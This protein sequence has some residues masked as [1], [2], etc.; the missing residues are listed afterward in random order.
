MRGGP[1][2]IDLLRHPGDLQMGDIIGFDHFPGHL[3]RRAAANAG[4]HLDDFKAG[5]KPKYRAIVLGTTLASN[6]GDKVDGILIFP[7]APIA[8]DIFIE[9]TNTRFVITK[10][11]DKRPT[12]LD[13]AK[14]WQV[15]YVPIHLPV[16]KTTMGTDEDLKVQKYGTLPHH[17]IT[18]I[19]DHT[20]S[21][22]E[23]R[24]I[25]V[26]VQSSRGLVR[27]YDN[28]HTS[29]GPAT[30]AQATRDAEAAAAA[31]HAKIVE[32]RAAR[33]LQ[34]KMESA[35]FTSTPSGK[36]AHSLKLGFNL[37]ANPDISLEDAH[38]LELI[39]EEQFVELDTIGERLSTRTLRG[40]YDAFV[41]DHDKVLDAITLVGANG[42]AHSLD[43]KRS[44]EVSVRN[45][46][47]DFYK[48]LRANRKADDNRRP[49]VQEAVIDY[50]AAPAAP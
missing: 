11:V 20:K 15:N 46:L 14:N 12:G 32:L 50:V 13:T 21:L 7:L 36:L 26:G 25:H 33:T 6:N 18:I 2:T 45:A 37:H 44:M 22:V 38:A 8:R 16:H 24:I 42:S 27:N 1:V 5:E 28:L 4:V 30:S 17:L 19:A 3:G 41:N 40:V 23:R 43:Y 39:S 34:A 31:D 35:E 10:L 48:I 47:T 49:M 9:M 29:V